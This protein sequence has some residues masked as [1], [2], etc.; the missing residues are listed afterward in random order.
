MKLKALVVA[1]GSLA[2]ALALVACGGGGSPTAPKDPGMTS[3]IPSFGTIVFVDAPGMPA[4]NAKFSI[5]KIEF[6]SGS[7]TGIV[8]QGTAS[9]NA[10]R[11]STATNTTPAGAISPH[12]NVIVTVY[13]SM[14]GVTPSGGSIAWGSLR[15]DTPV[16]TGTVGGLGIQTLPAHPKYLIIEFQAPATSCTGACDTVAS[17]P[18]VNAR[19]VVTLISAG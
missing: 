18:G 16:L 14:D 7:L 2:A 10:V 8:L 19:A 11:T 15:G 12:V 1:A 17:Q 3:T 13:P 6:V 4:S 9:I 5:D